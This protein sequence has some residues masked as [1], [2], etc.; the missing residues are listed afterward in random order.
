MSQVITTMSTKAIAT[1]RNGATIDGISTLSLI[2]CHCTTSG[3]SAASAAPIIP[4]ISAWLELDGSPMTHV[5]RFQVIAPT[6]PAITRLRV[7]AS[8]STMP[9]AIVAATSTETNAP[10]K[11]RTAALATARRG[12]KA[13]VETLV[14][15]EF[16]VS[17]NP[18]VKSKKRAIATTAKSMRSIAGAWLRVLDDDV[19]DRVRRRLAA[20]E[21]L[22]E[23]VV[24]VLPA[25]HHQRVD[26]V[27][28]E[29]RGEPVAQDAVA[30]VLEALQLD[31]R[32]LDASEPLQV[33]AGDQEL[34]TGRDEQRRLLHG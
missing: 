21:R 16:A 4:P 8:G 5:T 10:R 6:R 9:L 24:H 2:P 30:F 15:I 17:W 26:P 7:I 13:P 25:D 29:Q 19:G 11:L 28:A 18:F 31:E 3:P 20:V 14:A 32:V 22:F 1:P 23:P 12:L 27:V 33:V 34:L